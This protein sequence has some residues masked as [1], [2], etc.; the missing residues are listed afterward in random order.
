MNLSIRKRII[1]L[2]AVLGGLLSILAI[3]QFVSAYQ[4]L[5]KSH[6]AVVISEVGSLL[7]TAA[8]SWAVERGTTAGVLGAGGKA[9][10]KQIETINSRREMA[11]GALQRVMTLLQEHRTDGVELKEEKGV[12]D[13]WEAVKVLRDRVDAVIAAGSLD[14][15]PALRKDWFPGITGLIV[16]SSYLRSHVEIKLFEG[17][18]GIIAEAAIMRDH[19]WRWAEYAGRERGRLTGVISSGKPMTP[20]VQVAVRSLSESMQGS[21]TQIKILLPD[22]PASVGVVVDQASA[23]YSAEIIPLR[24]R[25]FAA[26][27]AGEPYPIT[28]QEWFETASTSIGGVLGINKELANFIGGQLEIV[29]RN[30]WIS[31]IASGLMLL[32]NV[33]VVIFAVRMTSKQIVDPIDSMIDAMGRMAGGDLSVEIMEPKGNDEISNMQRALQEFLQQARENEK[34]RSEQEAYR[35]EQEK[36]KEQLEE[37]QLQ[38]RLRLADEFEDV[39]GQVTASLA[40]NSAQLSSSVGQVKMDAD[41][42]ASK[43]NAA[44]GM[45]TETSEIVSNVASATSEL[46]AAIQ[47]VA[48]QIAAAASQT[49]DARDK[50]MEAANRVEDLNAASTAINEVVGLIADVAE[51]TNLLALNATIEAARAGESGKG[52]AV[53]ANEVKNLASQTQKATNEIREEI[54]NM[55]SKITET[56]ESVGSIASTASQVRDVV[57]GIAAATEE[58][59]ATTRDI[60]HSMKMAAERVESLNRE[61]SDVASLSHNTGEAIT[62]VSGAAEE[63]S[64]SS[65]LLDQKAKDF[66]VQIRQAPEAV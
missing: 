19:A 41:K 29:E 59:S 46:D 2:I 55:L 51:Q 66:L 60:S 49:N 48:S 8:G 45:A 20:A 21:I 47:E 35:L 7:V 37:K 10:Q 61:T 31:L 30:N 16:N 13:A 56:T 18:P 52:F 40:S 3:T 42:T 15:D 4:N 43:G 62:E 58:Q 54:T 14:G 64:T 11:D 34:Y 28:G 39:V 22:M 6:E 32:L 63:L 5:Q 57:Q 26:A 53:V 17:L 24:D 9:T 27:A 50:A 36:L 12:I 38:A 23:F 1:G 44:Q 65:Q 25:V 33:I